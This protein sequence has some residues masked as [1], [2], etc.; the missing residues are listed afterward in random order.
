[1]P[2]MCHISWP[3]YIYFLFDFFSNIHTYIKNQL[4]RHKGI[5]LLTSI[6]DLGFVYIFEKNNFEVLKLSLNK[7]YI[8]IANDD[9]GTL[10][11]S[12]KVSMIDF[13]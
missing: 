10:L 6:G 7:F 8:I 12:I 13:S 1:M 11:R 2:H 9:Y 3:Y 5:F 4:Y